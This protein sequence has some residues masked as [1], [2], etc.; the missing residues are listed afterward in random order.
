MHAT[1]FITYVSNKTLNPHQKQVL[2]KFKKKI[3]KNNDNEYTFKPSINNKSIEI[4]EKI[5]QDTIAETSK[6]YIS[7]KLAKIEEMR[8]QRKLKE[9]EGCTFHP[10]I[11][12]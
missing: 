12:P 1:D 8:K 3:K 11:N 6:Q 5:K 2:L 9:V 4:A 10:N 7:K